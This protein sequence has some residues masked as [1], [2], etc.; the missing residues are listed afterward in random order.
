MSK[1]TPL[2]LPDTHKLDVDVNAVGFLELSGQTHCILVL[3]SIHVP[4]ERQLL[5]ITWRK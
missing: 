5:L 2:D 3:L 4:R 1:Q